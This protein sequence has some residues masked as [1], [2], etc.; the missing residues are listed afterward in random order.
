MRQ[1]ATCF[2]EQM[3][4][5]LSVV[6]HR[7]CLGIIS[8]N[9]L[10]GSCRRRLVYY[11]CRLCQMQAWRK[12]RHV[13][14]AAAAAASRIHGSNPLLSP[15]QWRALA[16]YCE[17][18]RS[19]LP[20]DAVIP[21][22]PE[23]VVQVL[24]KMAD[25]LRSHPEV[26]C[27]AMADGVWAAALSLR[28]EGAPNRMHMAWAWGFLEA[29]VESGSNADMFLAALRVGPGGA[30]DIPRVTRWVKRGLCQALLMLNKRQEV[31]AF[32]RSAPRQQLLY[33]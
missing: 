7:A 15:S 21:S 16:E 23:E 33:F 29:C 4:L 18:V 26:L 1:K 20:S 25:Y 2:Y 32:L 27:Q 8:C 10:P 13:C 5:G 9:A 6:I 17:H 3:L 22:S 28:S 19:L 30:T 24:I 14:G 31:G 11:C 12:H